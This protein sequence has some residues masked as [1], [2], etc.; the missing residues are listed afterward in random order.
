VISNNPEV[1]FKEDFT[2]F[3]NGSKSYF[4]FMS[5]SEL[6]ETAASFPNLSGVFVAVFLHLLWIFCPL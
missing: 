6:E 2:E 1:L 3:E 4:L 5:H